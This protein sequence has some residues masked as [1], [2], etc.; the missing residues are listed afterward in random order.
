MAVLAAW[1]DAARVSGGAHSG[2]HQTLP[3]ATAVIAAA[4]IAATN[5]CRREWPIRPDVNKNLAA[6]RSR[7]TLWRVFP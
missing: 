6:G 2:W 5:V 3:P 1:Q 4:Q 7:V